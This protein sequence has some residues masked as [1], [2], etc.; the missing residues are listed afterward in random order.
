MLTS[1]TN[2]VLIQPRSESGDMNHLNDSSFISYDRLDIISDRNAHTS[3][4]FVCWLAAFRIANK[5]LKSV[6]LG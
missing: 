1:G 5:V 6:P 2:D 4:M 3:F